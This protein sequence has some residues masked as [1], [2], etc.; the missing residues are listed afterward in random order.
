[1]QDIE[2]LFK[3]YIQNKC[4]ADEIRAL[5][6]HFGNNVN[7]RE[8]KALIEQQLFTEIDEPSKEQINN[9]GVFDKTDLFFKEKLYP[10]PFFLKL[11]ANRLF[12]YAASIAIFLV[13]GFLLLNYPKKAVK[14]SKAN[15]VNTIS[16]GSNKAILKLSDGSTILLDGQNEQGLIA[17]LNSK[18]LKVKDG[19]LM[20]TSSAEKEDAEGL[21]LNELT[22]PAGGKYEVIL[23]DG[24]KVF[25]N[26]LSSLKYPKN[27]NDKERV[28]E[29]SGEAYFE[30]TKLY[31]GNKKVPFIVKTQKQT[32][33]VVGTKFNIS[34]YA[35][36][37]FQKTT[38]I[39]GHV[40]VIDNKN[41]QK[42]SLEPGDQAL[43][44]NNDH[45]N[46]SQ[47]NVEPSIAWTQ[48]NFMFDDVYLREILKQLARWYNVHVDY[49]NI[50]ETRYNILLSKDETLNSILKILE[51]TGE[52]K[53]KIVNNTIKIIN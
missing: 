16:P 18:I 47:V 50:P 22:I 8:L 53:F 35:D 1:M 6:D 26:S 31:K 12:K 40:N 11:P 51:D 39:S 29:L 43:T 36:D 28:V 3:R 27:F 46:V 14:D 38:L 32:I 30:V 41:H 9:S 42:Y 44:D 19:L 45:I 2:Q 15:Q 34:S 7:E 17:D 49:S 25:L 52:L 10:R 33:E 37:S 48:G 20:Y 23:S 24:T 4:S 5:I 13:A 21:L